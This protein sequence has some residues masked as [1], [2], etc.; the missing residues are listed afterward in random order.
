MT[1]S[2]SLSPLALLLLNLAQFVAPKDDKFWIGDMRLEAPFV[3]HKLQFA[4][5]ALGLAFKFRWKVLKHR[6]ATLAFASM[7]V[8]AVATLLFVPRIFNNPL[9][10]VQ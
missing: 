8:A 4:F 2:P 7:A 6:P 5:S 10:T 9:L 3:P 1:P